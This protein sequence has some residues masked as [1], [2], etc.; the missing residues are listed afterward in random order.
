M[1][2][3]T[4]VGKMLAEFLSEVARAGA[5][6]SVDVAKFPA[7]AEL[8]QLPREQQAELVLEVVQQQRSISMNDPRWGNVF[9]LRALLG[10]VL[11]KQL[12][13]TAEQLV[14]LLGALIGSGGHFLLSPAAILKAVEQ[15]A[16]QDALSLA[17]RASL[18]QLRNALR[19]RTDDAE[20]RKT[21]ERLDNLLDER[22]IL[23]MTTFDLTTNEAWT[24]QARTEL[25][26]L[27]DADRDNWYRLLRHCSGATSAKPSK[28]WQKEA[29]ALVVAIGADAFA[30]IGGR[31]IGEVGKPGSVDRRMIG[32]MQF[33]LDPTQVHDKH[34]DVL[35]GLVW[36]TPFAARESLF[37]IV[38][39]AADICFKKIPNIGPRAPKIGN[40]CLFALSQMPETGAVA[41]LSRLKTR[42]KHASVR[43][44]LAKA[45]DRAADNAG[46]SPAELE[47]VSVPSCGL[48]EVGESTQTIG[49]FTARLVADGMD[50]HVSWIKP[51][52]KAQAS[53]PAP[54]KT[55]HADD[56]KALKQR[57]KEI[58]K[59]LPAQ[60]DRIEQ[61]FWQPR[62]VERGFPGT[63]PQPPTRRRDRAPADLDRGRRC[64]DLARRQAGR[65]I[66]SP[67]PTERGSADFTL[68]SAKLPG[69]PGKGVARLAGFA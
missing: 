10:S 62:L 50:V 51:D 48:T 29:E 57:E 58:G 17:L 12:P 23:S 8:L 54:L 30:D 9:A 21:L 13:F 5:Y 3:D 46:L 41:Q 7:G 4:S 25:A 39:D 68:A 37:A 66:R 14:T 42:V 49:D 32:G 56:I 19:G 27:S 43:G 61:F 60:R 26:D 40:A 59:L 69:R 31:I 67:R 33:D 1:A 53:V 45:L 44:Q 11:R 24:Q 2:A 36:C 18:Q 6:L 63:L 47:E 15:H 28:K 16:R 55:S 38:G 34:S 64:G 20:S 52:G 65:R 22:P 35:R